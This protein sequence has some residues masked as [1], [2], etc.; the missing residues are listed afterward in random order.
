MQLRRDW[1]RFDDSAPIPGASRSRLGYGVTAWTEEDAMAL[2][3]EAVFHGKELSGIAA[4]IADVDVSTLDPDHIL[5]NME[6]PNRR[7][8]W[9]PRGFIPLQAN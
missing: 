9:F 4:V 6:P 2:L 3:R 7:G 1:F 8:V 5:P